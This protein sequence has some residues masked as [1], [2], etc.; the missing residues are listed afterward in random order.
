MIHC[1]NINNELRKVLE[2]L[3][4][5]EFQRF[6]SRL[7]PNIPPKSVL[8]VRLPKLRRIAKQIAKSDWRTF[9]EKAQDS[10]FEEVMLQG[11][12]IGYAKAE[13]PELQRWIAW[14]IP[15]IDNWSVCDSFCSGLKAAKSN[16]EEMWD[17]IVSYVQSEQEYGIRFGIVMMLFYYVD[18]VHIEEAFRL[19][20]AVEHDSYYVKMA[21]AWAVSIYYLS[22]PEETLEFLKD[23]SL[24]DFTYNKSLQK[25]TESR[26]VSGA[27]KEQIRRMKRK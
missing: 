3:A 27:V 6:S 9:L 12:V 17:F 15:K 26:K 18:S 11:M 10:S 24:D 21:A 20:D 14:F 7:I 4:E 8:G 2:S 25:I 16:P 23:C 22:F 19:L 5:P 13:L 1:G